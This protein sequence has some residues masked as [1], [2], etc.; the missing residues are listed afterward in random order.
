MLQIARQALGYSNA[1][2]IIMLP[3]QTTFGVW[4]RRLW[5]SMGPKVLSIRHSGFLFHDKFLMNLGY[6]R[7]YGTTYNNVDNGER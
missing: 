5:L 2:I 4:Q 6:T 1:S 3:T 7:L